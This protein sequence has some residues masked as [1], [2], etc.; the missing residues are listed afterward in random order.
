M[1]RCLD[2]GTF[3]LEALEHFAQPLEPYLF[4]RHA[5]NDRLLLLET[6]Q[7]T[8]DRE[9]ILNPLARIVSDR[10]LGKVYFKD[11]FLMDVELVSTGGRDAVANEMSRRVPASGGAYM[12]FSGHDK[13]LEEARA[14]DGGPRRLGLRL[15]LHRQVRGF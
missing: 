2:T 7:F 5:F 12:V 13:V 4:G 3:D 1:D 8:T 11:Y 14:R 6:T 10:A 15:L 9:T